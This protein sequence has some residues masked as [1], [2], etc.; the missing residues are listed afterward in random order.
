M[1]AENSAD[2]IK[3]IH[4]Y[5]NNFITDLGLSIFFVEEIKLAIL[6]CFL[7]LL[8]LISYPL[9]NNT[10]LRVLRKLSSKTNTTF[11][12][13]LI[14]NNITRYVSRLVPLAIATYLL[15]VI[16]ENFKQFIPFTEL[17]LS[18]YGILT[19]ILIFR[20]FLRATRDYL[21]TK[22]AFRDKPID[23]YIQVMVII[24]YFI[25]GILI[26]TTVTGKSVLAFFT[27]LGAA[28]AILLLIFK[29]T[30]LGFVASIQVT[31]NDMVRIGDW[32]TMEKYGA[33]GDVIEITLT[34]VKVQNFDKTITTIPTYNLISDSFKNWRG[35]QTWGGRR[36]KRP[37]KIKIASVKYLSEEDMERLSKIQL[38]A[39]YLTKMKKEIDADN[40]ENSI[41]RSLLINGRSL[42]NIGV[43][44][45]YID[46]YLKKNP[47]LHPEMT[48]MVRQL[49]PKH[50]GIPLE[51][52]AFTND[53][54]WVNYE[55]IMANIFDHILA[56]ANYFDL[57]IFEAP[58]SGDLRLFLK[59]ADTAI[60]LN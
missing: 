18:I 53:T 50:D 37:V 45:I 30:I 31:V 4:Q 29:D 14:K 6:L 40:A 5:L 36:I 22:D 35:M 20:A 57:E 2:I 28:S 10:L 17:L 23:S 58:S 12:D 3:T 51:I 11:D 54:K 16:L 56:A 38:I 15:P 52:Y 41:D 19:A 33:D 27:T 25:A 42:T 21:K 48:M 1:A 9:T 39:A 7:V 47:Y 43:F 24:L 34:T 49:E 8:I 59:K 55:N 26:F 32:I 44:R 13:Y 46:A 60:V